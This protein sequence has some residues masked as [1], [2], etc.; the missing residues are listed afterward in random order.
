MGLQVSHTGCP[1]EPIVA[2]ALQFVQAVV[3]VLLY[4]PAWHTV[5]ADAAVL[6]SDEVTNPPGQ[7]LHGTVGT[8]LYFPPAHSV[9]VVAPLPDSPSVT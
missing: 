6:A 4:G 3:D 2:P 9:H 7:R 8:E 5:Q 1:L